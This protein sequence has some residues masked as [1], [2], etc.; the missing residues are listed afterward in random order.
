M[1]VGI[2]VV[3]ASFSG[4]LF[5]L[6]WWSGNLS[7]DPLFT[8]SISSA[9]SSAAPS[10]A[11]PSA[12]PQTPAPSALP[13]PAATTVASQE[14]PMDTPPKVQTRGFQ[15]AATAHLLVR[16]ETEPTVVAGQ[17]V[18]RLLA[19]QQD[20]FHTLGGQFSGLNKNQVYRIT[21]WVKAAGG[22]NIQ[23]E[24][25]DQPPGQQPHHIA[26]IFSLSNHT[27]RDGDIVVKD[28]GID[29]GPNGWQKIWLNLLTA[30]GNLDV[31]LRPAN[32]DVLN[33]KG[34]GSLGMILG[35]V[36]ANPRS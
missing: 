10:S 12:R 9:S 13:A 26:A 36:E 14:A 32:G 31:T 5:A 35:G 22:G 30:D 23:L 18:L 16:Q 34:D 28:G 27:V 33:Y 1:I 8:A 20:G 4:T 3:A 19:S 29:Q 24:L 7:Y 11:A 2:V 21:A 6:N 25:G 15:W 17:P